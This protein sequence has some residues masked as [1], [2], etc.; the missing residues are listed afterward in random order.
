[1]SQRTQGSGGEADATGLEAK[2]AMIEDALARLADER[3]IE[4]IWER[5]ASVW[6]KEE[7]GQKIIKNALGWLKSVEF[8][9]DR[10]SDLQAFA[11]EV[12]AADFK[13]VMVL[14]MG[15][16][17]LCPEVLRQTFGKRKDDPELL[18]LDSTDPETIAD[19]TL[20]AAPVE[21]TLFV[22]ASK[23]GSTIEPLSF[24]KY[25]YEAVRAVKGE[26]AGEN[27]IAITDPGTLMERTASEMN[28]R[29]TFLNPPDIG[30]RYSAL[31]LFGM[32]PAILMGLDAGEM[33]RRA[34][35]M[36]AECREPV[37]SVGGNPAARLGCAMGALWKAGLDKLTVV[38]DRNLASLGL[39]IEQL[40]A[41]STGKR[42]RGILPVASET[43]GAPDVYGDDRLFVSIHTAA[44]D[45]DTE[46]KLEALQEAGFVVLRRTLRDPLDLGAEFFAWEMATA[47][48]GWFM[49]INPFDQPNVQESKDRTNE[50]LDQ[51]KE[52]K[53]LYA[54]G[55]P[56]PFARE[57]E[58]AVFKTEGDKGKGAAT[59]QTKTSVAA[60]ISEHLSS[61][62][63]GDYVALL[64]Y[65]QETPAH[66]ELLREI[67][68]RIR[69]SYRVA[70]TFGYG[71]RYLH[72]TGQLHK[73]GANNGIFILVTDEDET[74]AA[75]PGEPYSFSILKQAQSL[76][77]FASL[78]AHERRALRIHLGRETRSGLLNLLDIVKQ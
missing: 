23:S 73:G 19:F 62:R 24:Y 12:R 61:A 37:T 58:M 46:R 28:F 59:T 18:V 13:R 20:R 41:E 11:D 10:L 35:D 7:S 66:D 48:A 34:E 36:I 55:S 75:I 21:H 4:R 65:L 74:D 47:V 51:Y 38:T 76:G 32:L 40:V 49:E 33:L 9:S 77:D 43:L 16:S 71:P 50:L 63:D 78:A 26:R 57:G 22:V 52:S 60:A 14:G 5:D 31:S 56:E 54:S 8:V 6:T 44:P 3:I 1:M 67:G 29:R 25:F 45:E 69:A 64:A 27:F 72:S 2:S 30:G 53:S 17:S 70:T 39:W 42:E 15:G 68:D